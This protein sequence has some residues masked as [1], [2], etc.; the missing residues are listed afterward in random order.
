[1]FERFTPA[2]RQ[3]VTLAQT[4][5]RDMKHSWVGTEH[6][7]LGLAGQPDEPAARVLGWF[8]VDEAFVRSGILEIIGP[9]LPDA[10]ALETIGIDLDAVRRKIEEAFGP[11]AL[12]RAAW[13]VRCGSPLRN[14]GPFTARAKKVLHLALRESV[15]RRAPVV[16]TEHLLLGLVRE[17]EG[18]ASMIIARAGVD[19]VG[20][21][22][23]IARLV[24]QGFEA[25]GEA[26]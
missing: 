24:Q 7:L 8:G 17:G 2:A 19:L 6:L 10:A 23:A 25:H 9:G 14:A 26:G 12:E 20:V 5:A 13:H 22:A 4:S 3:A 21:E 1:M 11:G 15:R 16:G 18:V